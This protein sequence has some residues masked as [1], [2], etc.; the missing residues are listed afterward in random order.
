MKSYSEDLLH[1]INHKYFGI[2]SDFE[3]LILGN[4]PSLNELAPIHTF[5][6]KIITVN[7]YHLTFPAL[8]LVEDATVMI[9]PQY[10][11]DPRAIG[12][13]IRRLINRQHPVITVTRPGAYEILQ[14]IK[15]ANSKVDVSIIDPSNN[16]ENIHYNLTRKCAPIGQNVLSAAFL[17]AL[18]TG[19]KSI[20]LYGFDHN[21]MD[22]EDYTVDFGH[23]YRP[24]A[25]KD[26]SDDYY[27]PSTTKEIQHANFKRLRA[28]YQIIKAFADHAGCKI[29]NCSSRSSITTFDKVSI[30]CAGPAF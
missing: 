14:F 30:D 19:T 26:Y 5:G 8:W 9:D 3:V 7:E 29:V 16:I 18:F 25:Q 28:E 20:K 24:D 4:G 11:D 12:S 21:W 6:K 15:Y 23:A 17:F 2:W 13:V 10:W 22:A 27:P 1:E